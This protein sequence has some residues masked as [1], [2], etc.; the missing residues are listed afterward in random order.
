MVAAMKIAMLTLA[1]TA[2]AAAHDT[3]VEANVSQTP[4]RQPVYVDLKLGN[5]GNEHRDFKLAS[6]IPLEG[7]TLEWRKPDGTGV[8][9]KPALID[10]GLEAKEGY[11]TARIVPE[12]EGIHGLIHTYDAVVSYAP[13]RVIKSG[14]TYLRV[15]AETGTQCS[16][17]VGHPLE[18]VPLEDPTSKV[19][20]GTLKLAVIFKGELLEGAVVS[21][22]PAGAT[23]KEGFDPAHEAK[24]DAKGEAELPLPEANRYLVVVHRSAPEET[25]DGFSAGTSYAA[26]L[27]LAVGLPE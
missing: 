2:V 9:L 3:W 16:Q 18:I 11:W 22:V 24:T 12:T 27:T 26:T 4:P 6:K 13:K 19:A 17:A 23:L 1:L 10:Q 20:G 8:D 7:S 5:H 14:K 15:G 21:C 25:G